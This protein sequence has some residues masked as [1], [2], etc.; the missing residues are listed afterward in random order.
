MRRLHRNRKNSALRSLLKEH[1]LS[2]NDLV[3][4]LFLVETKKEEG[5]IASM[6]QQKRFALRALLE[7]CS[8]ISSLGIKALALFPV[9]PQEKRDDLASL[10]LQ[11]VDN[12]FYH[13]GIQAIK[14]EFPELLLIT[15]VAMDPYTLHGHDGII[16]KK[17][18]IQND[19]TVE[20][21][22]KMA[23]AQARAGADIVAPSDMMDAR[24]IAIRRALDQENFQNINILSYAVKYASAL[25]GPFREALCN[26]S[27]AINKK[28]YQI[29][30][31]NAREGIT[32]AEL[33]IAEG[34]D[35]LMLKPGSFYLDILY[36]LTEITNLPIAIYD[37]SGEYAMLKGIEK[38]DWC[39][40]RACVHEKLIAFK[41]A[42]ARMIFTYHAKE[43]ATW[44]KEG[45]EY[46]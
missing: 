28:S 14:K 8:I 31:S 41:R 32:E 4:P 9:V 30:P 7:E 29:L 18:E 13:K 44:L 20:V 36:R 42:G 1:T 34:A 17:G 38:E 25:Y 27:L 24:V 19:E 46:N 2:V 33:D 6:P 23:L 11:G 16:N 3:M 10:A 22:K 43:V 35:I 45:L 5:P 40:Y 15:D 39:N 12:N 21:L 26:K 37:V